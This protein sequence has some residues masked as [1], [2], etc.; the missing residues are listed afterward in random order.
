MI[1]NTASNFAGLRLKFQSETRVTWISTLPPQKYQ[2]KFLSAYSVR[3]LLD[4]YKFAIH[5][6]NIMWK[7]QW[8]VLFEFGDKTTK[9]WWTL[10]VTCKGD[11]IFLSGIL[12]RIQ[13]ARPR[14][15]RHDS[16]Q[17]YKII[18]RTSYSRFLRGW[19]HGGPIFGPGDR[20]LFFGPQPGGFQFTSLPARKFRDCTINYN[21]TPSYRTFSN[22]VLSQYF[23]AHRPKAD[24]LYSKGS[25][26][27]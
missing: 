9:I 13:H 15:R 26:L 1:C 12:L 14:H 7:A 27:G 21:M 16:Y 18:V 20:S 6:H 19:I 3:F 17:R 11:M 23:L 10:H 8:F 4:P 25:T 24:A 2:D 22:P 5:S